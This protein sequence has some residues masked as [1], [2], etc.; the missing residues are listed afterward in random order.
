[1]LVGYV[2]RLAP[3][4]RVRRLAGVCRLPGVRVVVVGDGPARRLERESPGAAFL[5]R[6]TGPE[7]AR[8]YPSLDV[9]VHTGPFETFGL[10]VLEAMAS[11]LP[12]VAP[13]GGGPLDLVRHGQTGFLVPPHD[14][15]ALGERVWEVVRSPELRAAFGRSGRI[16]ALAR[17]WEAVDEQLIDHYHQVIARRANPSSIRGSACG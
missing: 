5:G 8:I 10:T 6:R 14:D 13:A 7:L 15:R 12:V 9:F 2:G 1:V 4:K 16:D 3:E 17:S 11:G